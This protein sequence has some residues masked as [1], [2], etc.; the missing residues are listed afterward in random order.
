MTRLLCLLAL[1]VLIASFGCGDDDTS[2]SDASTDATEDTSTPDDTSVADTAVA[3]DTATGEDTGGVDSGGEDAADVGVDAPPTGPSPEAMGPFMVSMESETVRR[4]GRTIPTATYVPAALPAPALLLLPGF[5][6]S[7]SAY[8]GLC[9]RIASHG[10][11]VTRADPPASL[12]SVSH[13]DMRDDAIAVLDLMAARAD[14]DGTRL[15]VGGHSLGGK[16]AAMVAAMDSRPRALLLMDPVNGANPITGYSATVP[17]VVP[18]PVDSILAHTGI[19]GETTDAMPGLGGMACAPADQNF[20]TFYDAMTSAPSIAEWD[21]IGADHMDF[22][23]DR[24]ACGFAC[25]ACQSGSADDATVARQ[26][27]TL[28]TAFARRHLL[29]DA[30]M[31]PWLTGDLVPSSINTR[32]R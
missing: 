3:E 20:V 24:S 18:S 7:S 25:S 8:D 5:Q 1:L 28:A 12:L 17:D 29:G 15:G 13:T 22:L 14:V 9:R 27:T 16:V 10:V 30:S 26:V 11:L 4:G 32:T 19:M 21:F 23:S 6:I 31:E 2:E